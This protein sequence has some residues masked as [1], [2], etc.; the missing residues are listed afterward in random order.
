MLVERISKLSAYFPQSIR[1]GRLRSNQ[2]VI[3]LGIILIKI[4]SRGIHSVVESFLEPGFT[5]WDV[6][7]QILAKAFRGWEGAGFFSLNW[8]KIPPEIG[9]A[10]DILTESVA[11]LRNCK[12]C[13]KGF[14]QA[15]IRHF[16]EQLRGQLFC[17]HADQDAECASLFYRL[18]QQHGCTV[19]IFG[20]SVSSPHIL[21]AAQ[22][23]CE[24]A[25]GIAV[26]S[27]RGFFEQSQSLCTSLRGN[28][29]INVV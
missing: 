4:V 15:G 9:V 8:N 29:V 10:D 25:G 22:T 20:E 3:S 16:L 1:F 23:S 5:F 13:V 21:F 2:V 28:I 19:I 11:P 27:G 17:P 6:F 14:L 18:V 24:N 26:S 12:H 7:Y